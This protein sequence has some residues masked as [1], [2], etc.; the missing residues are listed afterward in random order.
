MLGTDEKLLIIGSLN[1]NENDRKLSRDSVKSVQYTD[2]SGIIAEIPF[3]HS[4]GALG[5]SSIV[6]VPDNRF[7]FFLTTGTQLFKVNLLESKIEEIQIPKLRGV[8]ELSIIGNILW[9]TNTFYD[10]IIS[11]DIV[12]GKLIKRIKLLTAERSV[13][14]IPESNV[15]ATDTEKI[16]KFHCNQVFETFEGEIY[17]LVH[18]VTGEQLIKRIAQKIIK[19]QGNGGVLDINSEKRLRLKLKAPH[20]VRKINGQYWILNSG[21]SLLNIYSR[22]WKLIK[23]V[24]TA[25]W[26]RGADFSSVTENYFCG[27]SAIRSRYALPGSTVVP[28]M[29]EVF[30]LN[31]KKQSDFIVPDVE[32]LNNLYIV[33]NDV[34]EKLLQLK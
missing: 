14:F 9:I 17:A 30:D 19:S 21:H 22:E 28:N 24:R 6:W 16:N 3:F 5:V 27:V 15:D 12:K 26:C 31:F 34:V 2:N 33:K 29:V 18:H 20:T 13:E 10:E 4:W 32:Q 11:Y 23:E 8:H 25:G 7:S 1:A